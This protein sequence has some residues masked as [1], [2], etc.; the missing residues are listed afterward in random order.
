MPVKKNI[1]RAT[2][3]TT[4]TVPSVSINSG[5]LIVISLAF[6]IGSLM[7]Y[8]YT[9]SPRNNLK[10]AGVA[11]GAAQYENRTFPPNVSGNCAFPERVSVLNVMDDGAKPENSLYNN[12]NLNEPS[13]YTRMRVPVN[14]QT[15]N[16]GYS[17][18]YTQIGYLSSAESGTRILPLFGRRCTT[19]KFQYYTLSDTNFS[20]KLPLVVK[21]RI[22]TQE[23]G[24]DEVYSHDTIEVQNLGSFVVELYENSSL[25]YLP[26]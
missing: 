8:I 1:I 23:T 5:N 12:G 18:K 21:G 13:N 22:S 17:A 19:N 2:A 10:T 4:A 15:R 16:S 25:A 11:G 9:T 7:T 14:V 26:L 20:I 3:R 24:V 6:L